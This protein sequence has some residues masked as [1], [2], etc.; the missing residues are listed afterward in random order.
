MSLR[1]WRF[2]TKVVSAPKLLPCLF[3]EGVLCSHRKSSSITVMGRCFECDTYKI[4]MFR[5]QEEDEEEDALALAEFERV[6]KFAFCHFERCYCD[7]AHGKL[8]CFDWE[9]SDG[10]VRV[11]KCPRFRPEQ[12]GADSAMRLAYLDLVKGL[13]P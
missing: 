13:S 6:N 3:D 7:G 10:I 2:L 12:L 11:W 5:M 9:E 8:S 4:C 1:V